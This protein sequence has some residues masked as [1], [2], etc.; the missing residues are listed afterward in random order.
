MKEIALN[1]LAEQMLRYKNIKNTNFVFVER[2]DFI[3]EN[4]NIGVGQIVRE[5]K[6]DIIEEIKEKIRKAGAY[7]GGTD[8]EEF[9]NKRVGQ[10]R[11][12]QIQGA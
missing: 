9:L 7:T 12:A 6:R 5:E 11:T 2:K 8:L 10:K 1:L 4:R 3:E